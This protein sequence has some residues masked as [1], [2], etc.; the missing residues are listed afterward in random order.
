MHRR[1]HRAARPIAYSATVVLFL[2]LVLLINAVFSFT[3]WPPFLKRVA[4]DERSTDAAGA[5]TR[6]FTV[7]LVLIST[8]LVLA[9]VAFVAAVIGFASLA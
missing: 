7:H 9:A 6:F 1:P 4:A 2:S 8:A 3:V 5:R